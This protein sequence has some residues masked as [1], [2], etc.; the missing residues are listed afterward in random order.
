V[1]VTY[2]RRK[3]AVIASLLALAASGVIWFSAA[4]LMRFRADVVARA[5]SVLELSGPVAA[6]PAG[7][8]LLLLALAELLRPPEP[9]LT[10]LFGLAFAWFAAMLVLPIVAHFTAGEM[11]PARGYHRCDGR[12]VGYTRPAT[13]WVR[14]PALCR[15]PV[16]P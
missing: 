15:R 14:D 4:E 16:A 1:E 9:W 2:S 8:T 6:L 5:P 7:L 12:V 3:G 13:R 10:R 11:L